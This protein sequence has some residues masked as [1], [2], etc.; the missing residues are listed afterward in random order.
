[1]SQF[2]GIKTIV[3]YRIASINKMFTLRL[4]LRMA[5]QYESQQMKYKKKDLS[6]AKQNRWKSFR[7]NAITRKKY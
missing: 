6:Y 7:Y 4:F 1:M 2:W 3:F 5:L